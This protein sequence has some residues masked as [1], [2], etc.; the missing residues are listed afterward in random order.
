MAD[1][2]TDASGYDPDLFVDPVD[3]DFVCPICT[4]VVRDP[5]RIPCDCVATIYCTLCLNT[6][7]QPHMCPTCRFEFQLSKC[8]SQGFVKGKVESLKMKCQNNESGC[9]TTFIIGKDGKNLIAH[10]DTCQYEETLCKKCQDPIQRMNL[11]EH[12]KNLCI[13]R[14]ITCEYCQ[15]ILE[16]KEIKIH[17]ITNNNNDK[18]PL[19]CVNMR[20]CINKDCEII[21]SKDNID[22]HLKKC[23][24]S[25]KLCELCNQN[26]LLSNY[27]THLR[28][29]LMNHF[30][31]LYE[32]TKN[33]KEEIKNLK[34]EHKNS[35]KQ[36]N[37]QK[38]EIKNLNDKIIELMGEEVKEKKIR[39]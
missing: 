19:P 3:Q 10:K 33:L 34:D 39:K 14:L 21:V 29:S 5:K 28:D 27:E 15:Q 17:Q 26:I 30:L 4:C 23:P 8:E 24:Y 13:Y 11:D 7:P 16:Y 38:F 31:S 18:V 12:N 9:T 2:K 20:K 22:E 32:E 25:L 36:I 1:Q 35:I 6:L 37:E